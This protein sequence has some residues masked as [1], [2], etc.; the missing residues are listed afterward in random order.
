[1]LVFGGY[2]NA[3]VDGFNVTSLLIN[4]KSEKPKGSPMREGTS[5]TPC[6]GNNM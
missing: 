2:A 5:H 6:E 3:L 4:S 1:M